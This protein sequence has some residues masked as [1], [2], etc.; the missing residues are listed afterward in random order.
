VSGHI[1]EAKQ[2][3]PMPALLHQLGLGDRARRSARCPLP[4]HEDENASFGIFKTKTD[5]W[6]FKCFSCNSDGDEIEFLRQYEGLSNGD[7][8]RRY[9][10]LAGVN[11]SR[12]PLGQAFR[13]AKA[14]MKRADTWADGKTGTLPVRQ[15][16]PFDW[17]KCADAFTAEH[18]ERLC[19]WRGFSPEFVSR[20]AKKS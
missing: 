18:Q 14:I 2:K 7:A 6:R 10:E 15:E 4:G 17:Q 8:L 19:D 9:L 11:G 16:S 1:E 20:C 3:L 5:T 13:K 12:P